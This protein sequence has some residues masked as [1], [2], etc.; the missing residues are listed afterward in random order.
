MADDSYAIVGYCKL[1]FKTFE[2]I[3]HRGRHLAFQPETVLAKQSRQA[4]QRLEERDQ[5]GDFLGCQ[6]KAPGM[7]LFLEHL[8]ERSGAAVVEQGISAAH[9]AQ[10][11]RV[12]LV[13][14]YLVDQADVV[15]LG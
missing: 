15:T 5:I 9:A 3:G 10:R 12:E 2:F 11:G 14:A 1:V 6:L 7:P 4:S 13:I 8:F